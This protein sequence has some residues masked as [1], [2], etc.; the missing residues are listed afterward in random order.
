MRMMDLAAGK[1]PTL[2]RM[3]WLDL[4]SLNQVVSLALAYVN[5]HLLFQLLTFQYLWLANKTL[6]FKTVE[7]S[8][9]LKALGIFRKQMPLWEL[10]KFLVNKINNRIKAQEVRHGIARSVTTKTLRLLHMQMLIRELKTTLVNIINNKI[11]A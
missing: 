7:V 3:A 8:A 2:L 9:Q 1:E 5:L 10:N 6:L 4:D 11:K